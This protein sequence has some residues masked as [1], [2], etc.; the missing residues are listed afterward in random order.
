MTINIPDGYAYI[1]LLFTG[2]TKSGFATTHV[3]L[4]LGGSN[5]LQSAAIAVGTA[6]EDNVQPLQSS[7]FVLTNIRAVDNNNVYEYN[8]N[9]TGGS[10]LDVSPANVSVLVKSTTDLRGREHR[11]RQYLPGFAFDDKIADD[12][13]LNPAFYDDLTVALNGFGTDLVDQDL[14]PVI[15]HSTTSDSTPTPVTGGGV[16]N[17]V[18][19]QRRR[20]R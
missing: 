20:L 5:T 10:S 8:P 9:L 15:L 18:A 3:S 13:T 14:Y 16:E 2:L 1:T 12:G 19:T 4:E 17:K 7:Y 11:G 6:W